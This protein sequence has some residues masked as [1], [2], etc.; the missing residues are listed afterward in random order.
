MMRLAPT[1]SN[2]YAQRFSPA[3]LH[4][5]PAFG[6]EPAAPQV[7]D[8]GPAVRLQR[9]AL[10]PVRAAG[11]LRLSGQSWA[12]LEQHL[13]RQVRRLALRAAEADLRAVR[14]VAPGLPHGLAPDQQQGAERRPC[15][16]QARWLPS[17]L[18]KAVLRPS[19][20]RKTGKDLRLQP[21]TDPPRRYLCDRLA[22]AALKSTHARNIYAHRLD[23]L[24]R[25]L[26]G[27]TRGT[28]R[29]RW[30]RAGNLSLLPNA[31]GLARLHE[32]LPRL[33]PLRLRARRGG[34]TALAA[35]ALRLRRGDLDLGVR[36]KLATVP[37]LPGRGVLIRQLVPADLGLGDKAGCS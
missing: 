15:Q 31:E 22:N 29:R 14:Q 21:R 9:I 1:A 24:E 2:N 3:G 4:G 16:V 20:H 33:H 19:L 6:R 11:P 17:K 28:R 37:P 32:R 5:A 34:R 23:A 10:P 7:H 35:A 26:D 13:E 27:P 18:E 30:R 25:H 8:A 36:H 12:A